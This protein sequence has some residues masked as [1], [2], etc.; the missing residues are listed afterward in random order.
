MI[1]LILHL[2]KCL[3][4]LFIHKLYFINNLIIIIIIKIF[5]ATHIFFVSLHLFGHTI[6][7]LGLLWALLIM[8]NELFG[9][10]FFFM[11]VKH[12]IHQ[13]NI[14]FL[15]YQLSDVITNL[16]CQSFNITPFIIE[17]PCQRL[18]DNLES[19]WSKFSKN[20]GAE[21]NKFGQN[22]DSLRLNIF[23]FMEA[24]FAN[25]DVRNIRGETVLNKEIEAVFCLLT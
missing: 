11:I 7:P 17:E 19:C 13:I 10:F 4:L 3:I 6:F 15:S 14:I 22:N 9:H 23:I 24:L 20:I 25:C 2:R 8:R 18:H 12:S 5:I 21:L 16:S 1:I